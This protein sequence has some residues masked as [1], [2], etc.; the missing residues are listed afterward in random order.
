MDLFFN[1][2]KS[3]LESADA[4]A[5]GIVEYHGCGADSHGE[6]FNIT[7]G[8][9][10]ANGD[11][12]FYKRYVGDGP[13][14]WTHAW[15]YFGNIIGQVWNG[16]IQ[17][18]NA[19]EM[20]KPL[21]QAFFYPVEDNSY[22]CD[23]Y[24]DPLNPYGGGDDDVT[25][26][27]SDDDVTDNDSES[28]YSDNGDDSDNN[29]G[30]TPEHVYPVSGYDDDATT[31]APYTTEPSDTTTVTTTT[32]AY[33][34]TTTVETTV[35]TTFSTIVF[36][37]DGGYAVPTVTP[38]II[39]EPTITVGPYAPE[40]EST[41]APETDSTY[42]PETESTYSPET[43]PTYSP[44]TEPTYSPET[45]PTFSPETEPTY[46]PETEPT[47]PPETE[48]TYSPETEPTYAPE[49]EP[50]YSPETEPTNPPET[51]PTYSP[52]TEP[53]YSPETEPTYSPE[54]EPTYSP[55]TE[56]TVPPPEPTNPY[57]GGDQGS[58]EGYGFVTDGDD[59][60]SNGG[61]DY[62]FFD[63]DSDNSDFDAPHKT[64]SELVNSCATRL[65][66]LKGI[67]GSSMTDIRSQR[68]LQ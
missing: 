54:T 28:G 50:T 24:E 63:G 47:N 13:F 22:T 2:D 30:P 21:T 12:Q 31:L 36:T 26:D 42:S 32:T 43:E 59:N 52:E 15:R 45:E 66:Q 23:P 17:Y 35:S 29:D 40:T 60:N 33:T 37:T 68:Q 5:Y 58:N 38:T 67:Y 8:Y 53:T 14:K 51:E 4:Y 3:D 65:S 39:V 6:R 55:E 16:G 7:D 11:W 41:Y 9:V 64:N 27:T 44:E 1:Y 62:G 57:N 61:Y 46:A 34:S 10:T 56:P 25:D 19:N 18:A 20:E 49:T 48:P